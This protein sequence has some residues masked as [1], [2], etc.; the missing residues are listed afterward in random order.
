MQEATRKTTGSGSLKNSV[1]SVAET[2]K[3]TLEEAPPAR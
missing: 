2:N 3:P 1:S